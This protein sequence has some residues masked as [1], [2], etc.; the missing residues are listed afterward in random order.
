MGNPSAWPALRPV[1]V[2]ESNSLLVEM[3]GIGKAFPTSSGRPAWVVRDI[4][5]SVQE[6][7]FLT[8]VG[9]S[10]SGKTTLLR[11]I[12][13]IMMP[14]E[15]TV[16][17]EG[18]PIGRPG[19]DRVMVFQSSEAALFEWLTV[20][21][22]VEF[23]LRSLGMPRGPRALRSTAVLD[24]VGLSPHAKKFPS[25]LSGGMQQRLQI[26]RAIAV[27][28]KLLLMDEPLAALDAQTRR[29]LLKELVRL[30]KETQST[31]I[32]V[33][34]DIREAVLLGG[35][36]VVVSSGPSACIRTVLVNESPYPRDEFGQ[37]FM[38]LFRAID[39]QLAAEVGEQL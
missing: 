13:G 21:Q 14:S 30:W 9:P 33:T 32:Y 8:I 10:G 15:G 16:E 3:K 28:P 36:I 26:A 6:G 19:S 25:Q 4:S 17:F 11:L 37:D 12:A 2:P 35:R 23:G 18:R 20:K 1:F 38:A 34:H 7:E 22:N 31:F 27:Q 39:D 5:L 24:L 29:I